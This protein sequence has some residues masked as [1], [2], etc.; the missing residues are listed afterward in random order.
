MCAIAMLTLAG[1]AANTLLV[2]STV[3]LIRTKSFSS[4]KRRVGLAALVI[5]CWCT[6]VVMQELKYFEMYHSV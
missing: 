6:T 4:S 5:V 3:W 2:I 1:A